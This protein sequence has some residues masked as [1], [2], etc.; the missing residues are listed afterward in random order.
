VAVV[1]DLTFDARVWKEARSLANAG[2]GVRLIGCHYGSPKTS[3]RRDESI[4]VFEVS[5]GS[6][7]GRISV[8]GRARSLLRLWL[9]VLHTRARVYHAHNIHVGPAMWLAASIRGAALIYDGHELYGTDAGKRIGDR[10]AARL[11]WQLER[12]LVRRSDSVIT[13]NP[14]RADHLKLRHGDRPVEVLANVPKRVDKLAPLDPGYPQGPAILLYQ[15]GVYSNN[16]AFAQT[17]DALKLLTGVDLVI[18]GFGRERNLQLIRQWAEQAGVSDRVHLLPP[19]PFEDLAHTAAAATIGLVPLSPKTLNSYLGDTNKLF[20]YLMG[21]IPVAASD[22][23]E[24][25]RVVT[26]GDPPV[27]ELFD[28][29]SAESIAEAVSKL[30]ADP[31]LYERRRR[32]ARRLA[33][34]LFNWEIEE[35]RLLAIYR[36]LEPSH[37][38]TTGALD[39][40]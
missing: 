34:E 31:E 38:A 23:P 9:E 32:E 27:G 7:S 19:R 8:F 3:N 5:L 40:Q 25:R 17:I 39:Q 2:Y 1:S 16:R 28:P 14:S 6:R 10:V 24:I 29:D 13:T 4:D 18:T 33:L 15:G 20:E 37:R 30:L 22:L 35:R 26:S 11:A 21:G 36:R 12:F